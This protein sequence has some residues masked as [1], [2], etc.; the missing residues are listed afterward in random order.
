MIASF[1]GGEVNG[2]AC[3]AR[4][5]GRAGRAEAIISGWADR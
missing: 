4:E 1:S 3:D 5:L 2:S